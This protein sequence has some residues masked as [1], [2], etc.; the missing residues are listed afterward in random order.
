FAI[1]L[2]RNDFIWLNMTRESRAHIAGETP[3][4]FLTHYFN[5]TD[6]MNFYEFFSMLAS[7]VTDDISQADI[8]VSDLNVN[9]AE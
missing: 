9:A 3:L 6:I 5:V 4:A 7:E 1:D 2:Q 8:I